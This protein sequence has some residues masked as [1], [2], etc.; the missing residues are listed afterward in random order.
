MPLKLFRHPL[1]IAATL[2]LCATPTVHA[3]PITA[4]VDAEAPWDIVNGINNLDTGNGSGR[5]Y[6]IIDAGPVAISGIFAPGPSVA[7]TNVNNMEFETFLPY[8]PTLDVPLALI[9]QGDDQNLWALP[10]NFFGFPASTA[11]LTGLWNGPI[12]GGTGAVA[13]LFDVDQTIFGFDLTASD[14]PNEGEPPAS[15]IA[16]FYA[17]DGALIDTLNLFG[18]PGAVAQPQSYS[19]R[20]S[21]PGVAGML[22]TTTDNAGLAYTNLRVQIP[23]PPTVALMAVS[24]LV[25][26]LNR[27]RGCGL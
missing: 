1:S 23:G 16:A 17:R 5:Q 26:G 7:G 22:L 25:L 19:F 6:G 3:N 14:P 2:V 12:N 24:L 15:L 10:G 27:R 8:P 11:V 13:F 9:D 4:T 20:S 21:G 18:L